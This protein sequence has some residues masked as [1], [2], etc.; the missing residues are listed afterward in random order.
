MKIKN[1]IICLIILLIINS[2]NSTLTCMPRTKRVEIR[3]IFL[4][5]YYIPSHKIN[6]NDR[7]CL[8]YKPWNY[9]SNLKNFDI[10]IIN[11]QLTKKV[12]KL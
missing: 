8:M 2:C 9:K 4:N 7:Y 6:T 10:N 5:K 3:D 1:V 11:S 12:K